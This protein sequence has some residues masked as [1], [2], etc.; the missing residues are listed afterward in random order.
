MSVSLPLVIVSHGGRHERAQAV[1]PESAAAEVQ[2]GEIAIAHDGAADE[3]AVALAQR[4]A[5]AVWAH[6]GELAQ[7]GVARDGLDELAPARRGEQPCVGEQSEQRRLE[8]ASSSGRRTAR[9][10]CCESITRA[11][12]KLEETLGGALGEEGEQ[13]HHAR[14]VE[15]REER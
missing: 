11:N 5:D 8:A 1:G 6:H 12:L 10:G 15:A 4:L 14:A 13:R 3:R 7:R 2:R 9:G